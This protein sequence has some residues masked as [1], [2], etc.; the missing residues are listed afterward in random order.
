MQMYFDQPC[1]NL[2]QSAFSNTGPFRYKA[3][4]LWA[5]LEPLTNLY[6]LVSN[7]LR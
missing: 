4:P 7:S 3:L 6:K 5:L 1:Y 2:F